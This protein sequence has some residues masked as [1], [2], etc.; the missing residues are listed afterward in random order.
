MRKGLLEV[1]KW[2]MQYIL[3]KILNFINTQKVEPHLKYFFKDTC[4]DMNGRRVIGIKQI[5]FL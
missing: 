3:S 5:K 1:T 2:K 4:T